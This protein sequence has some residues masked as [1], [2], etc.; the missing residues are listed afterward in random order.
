MASLCMTMY[1]SCR[2][3]ASGVIVEED[4]LI[5]DEICSCYHRCAGV[6]QTEGEAA[7]QPQR[8]LRHDCQRI[9][10]HVLTPWHS[11]AVAAVAYQAP[12]LKTVPR[13]L[14]L[15]LCTKLCAY[16]AVSCFAINTTPLCLQCAACCGVL[17]CPC[18]SFKL[19]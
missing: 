19:G 11:L 8:M 6:A 15:L 5:V 17:P 14:D 1:R 18:T 2:S 10:A 7:A 9:T 3:D 13:P 16:G 12:G 4:C